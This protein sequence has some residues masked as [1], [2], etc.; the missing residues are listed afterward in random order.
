MPRFNGIPV[1]DYEP[2]KPRFKGIPV[3][4]EPEAAPDEVEPRTAAGSLD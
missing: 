1:E 4:D 3:E 2:K